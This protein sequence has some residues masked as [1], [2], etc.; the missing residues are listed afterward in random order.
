[1][2]LPH[3]S[4]SVI[5]LLRQSGLAIADAQQALL[6]RYAAL[7]LEWNARI[8]LISRKD[9]EQL[10]RNH[11]LHSLAALT[12]LPFPREGRITDIGSGGGLPGIP[13]AIMLPEVRF[14]LVD[15]VGKKIRA[16]G[17]M[18]AALGL[19]NIEVIHGRVEE[20]V[21]LRAHA[22]T[23]DMVTARAVT[24]LEALVRW[25]RPLLRPGGL[26]SLVVWKGGD[27]REEI[28]EARRN[29]AL[30]GV[31]EI[32]IDIPGEPYFRSEE[33]KLLSIRYR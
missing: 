29:P 10:W 9:Q 7:L 11:I 2:S 26:R 17:E 21:V 18:A 28:A 5:A 20:D 19:R 32:P 8:N 23:T 25:T 33:K 22:G 30:A 4:E 15:S 13:L 31:E 3:T 24:R 6:T 27:L 14:L 12:H 1:M 16:V